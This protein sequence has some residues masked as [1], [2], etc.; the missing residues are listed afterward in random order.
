MDLPRL[1]WQQYELDYGSG[2]P[3]DWRDRP[4]G[5]DR[6]DLI[7][8]AMTRTT[9]LPINRDAVLAAIRHVPDIPRPRDPS[10]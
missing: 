8:A 6:A 9:G 2:R 4:D 5:P 1:T 7:A 10:E 3:A